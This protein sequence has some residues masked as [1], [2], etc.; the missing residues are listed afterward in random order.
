MLEIYKGWEIHED[1]TGYTGYC[2]YDDE[3]AMDEW[4]VTIDE[5]KRLIDILED[6]LS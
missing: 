4:A 6:D 3:G 1:A 2:P 5:L